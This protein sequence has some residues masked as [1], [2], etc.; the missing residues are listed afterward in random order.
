MP[1]AWWLDGLWEAVSFLLNLLVDLG[2]LVLKLPRRRC[3]ASSSWLSYL[4][5]APL[6]TRTC[7][8]E[9]PSPVF[10][11]SVFLSTGLGPLTSF[12]Q[13]L[14]RDGNVQG[15]SPFKHRHNIWVVHQCFCMSFLSNLALGNIFLLTMGGGR[16]SNGILVATHVDVAYGN[17]R[18]W[19]PW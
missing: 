16:W 7:C 14:A 13:T 19:Q 5:R 15:G 1:Q 17:R 6:G 2:H 11:G 4:G 3:Y 8:R 12:L 9:Q 18:E 10:K